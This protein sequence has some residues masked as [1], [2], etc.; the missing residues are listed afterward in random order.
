[1]GIRIAERI[2]FE[3]VEMKASRRRTEKSVGG[4]ERRCRRRFFR[5]VGWDLSSALG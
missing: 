3:V 2:K 5:V 1:M 4:E